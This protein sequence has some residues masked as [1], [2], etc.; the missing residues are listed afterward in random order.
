M[1]DCSNDPKAEKAVGEGKMFLRI[2]AVGHKSNLGQ[3]Q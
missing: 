3:G 1:M 2:I